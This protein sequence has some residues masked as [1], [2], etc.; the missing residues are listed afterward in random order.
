MSLFTLDFLISCLVCKLFD[1][2]CVEVLEVSY[3]LDAE[4]EH[5]LG[6]RRGSCHVEFSNVV[7][8]FNRFELMAQGDSCGESCKETSE[9]GTSGHI[10]CRG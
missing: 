1:Q 2:I 7:L 6:V 9:E 5:L 3:H 8:C 10:S 4:A